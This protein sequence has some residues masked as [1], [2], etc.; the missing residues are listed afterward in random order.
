MKVSTIRPGLLVSLKT[1]IIGNVLYEKEML[2]A[3]HR[4]ETGQR[5][6]EW[7]TKRTVSDAD[8]HELATVT[9]GKVR[10]TV[11]RVCSN[12]AFG[13]LCPED[14]REEF[15][16][17]VI[18]ARNLT[19]EFNKKAKLSHIRLYVIAGRIASD[20]AEAIRAINS[21]M[22]DL[23]ERMETGIRKLDVETV[24]D[25]A[26]KAKSIGQMLSPATR[27]RVQ[28]AI[29]AARTTA[30]AMVKAGTQAATAIDE[31][32]IKQINQARTSFL[33]LSDEGLAIPNTEAA[34]AQQARA[35]DLPTP[36]DDTDN[37]LTS[38]DADAGTV[39]NTHTHTQERQ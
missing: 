15:D 36:D 5:I 14:K 8:E 9:R 6:A 11:A 25:A 3:D 30:R 17:A 20:D 21:E 28:T 2:E 23:L 4:T 33:D 19:E 35:I 31:E 24:R 34:T 16:L 39:T 29:D 26:N 13:L 18:E 32:L 12:S 38:A 7:K 10:A 1:S 27:Q 22:T 37:T